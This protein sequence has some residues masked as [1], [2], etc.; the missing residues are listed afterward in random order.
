[1]SDPSEFTARVRE[2]TAAL[3]AL[4][5]APFAPPWPC[6]ADP[7]RSA[8]GEDFAIV[9]LRVSEDFPLGQG[10]GDEGEGLDAAHEA[11]ETERWGAVLALDERWGAHGHISTTE[12][13]E[14]DADGAD[15][16]PFY[17]ALIELGYSGPLQTWDT[18][19]RTVGIGVGQMDEE[20]PVVLYAVALA[21]CD[22]SAP[23]HAEL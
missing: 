10:D 20:E 14:R 18:D 5:T 6:C 12:Y 9:A 19:G 23:D 2:T 21:P 8:A 13:E 7:G 3:E 17:A 11:F 1:M 22:E 16:P 15:V 4:R